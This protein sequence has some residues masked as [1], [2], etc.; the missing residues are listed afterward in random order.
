MAVAG[1]SDNTRQHP[2]TPDNSQ[3]DPEQ[4]ACERRWRNKYRH[5]W[6]ILPTRLSLYLYKPY[7]SKEMSG[8]N[9][10]FLRSALRVQPVE[11]RL[12]VY[13]RNPV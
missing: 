6:E 3:P 1:D 2:G 4:S 5:C 12:T 9:N 10:I 7:I 13:R 11:T 8:N